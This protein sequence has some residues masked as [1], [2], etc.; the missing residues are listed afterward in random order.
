MKVAL[1]TSPGLFAD[2]L[3][4]VLSELG[5]DVA[6]WRCD[7]EAPDLGSAEFDFAL[8]LPSQR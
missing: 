3:R 2:G 4:H 1:F 7:F 6:T 8:A 5:A